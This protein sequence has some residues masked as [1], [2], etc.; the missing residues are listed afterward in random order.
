MSYGKILQF[1][2]LSQIVLRNVIE[3]ELNFFNT[4]SKFTNHFLSFFHSCLYLGNNGA[5]ILKFVDK[6]AA[7][8]YFQ[9]ATDYKYIKR[10]M[11][12][13]SNTPLVLTVFVQELSG[14]L[15]INIPP[16]PSDRLWYGFRGDPNLVLS[17]RPRLG[18]HR[19]SM[20]HAIEWIE[21]K[22]QQEFNKLL[23][24][25]NMDDIILSVMMASNSN[26]D[27]Q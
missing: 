23:V 15:S 1:I 24:I 21:K 19:V 2:P 17:A 3:R 4:S 10:A 8:K 5:K 22:L 7:S 6:L 25:P 18:E 16:P 13:V 20:S 9:Q 27:I 12:G 26:I 14:V 11:E